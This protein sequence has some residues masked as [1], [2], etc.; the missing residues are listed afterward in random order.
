MFLRI[1]NR[2]IVSLTIHVNHRVLYE[3]SRFPSTY[4]ERYR[5]GWRQETKLR[6]RTYSKDK[7]YRSKQESRAKG[8]RQRYKCRL[9]YHLVHK[10]VKYGARLFRSILQEETVWKIFTSIYTQWPLFSFLS[11]SGNI[12]PHVHTVYA[13]LLHNNLNSFILIE[14]SFPSKFWL[15]A[16]L[17]Y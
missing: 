3:T 8:Y 15:T 12:R 14:T 7:Q 2:L 4:E 5:D 11:F 13:P 6:D 16:F 10:A 9:W 1:S 17:S